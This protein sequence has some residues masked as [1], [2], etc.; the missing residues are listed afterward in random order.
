MNAPGNQL[1]KIHVVD[2]TGTVKRI[3]IFCGGTK[4]QSDL[5][6]LF[7]DLE[8]A[9]HTTNEVEYVFSDQFIHYDDSI[10]IIKKKNCPR[11]RNGRDLL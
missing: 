11:I 10:R 8:L 9:F 4:T 2:S 6:E 1:Y 3:H 7:S 5:A